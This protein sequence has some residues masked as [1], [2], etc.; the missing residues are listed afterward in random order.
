[1]AKLIGGAVQTS[2]VTTS[3]YDL[4]VAATFID[5]DRGDP[6]FVKNLSI[7]VD[8]GATGPVYVGGANLTGPA[9]AMVVLAAGASLAEILVTY[10][11]DLRDIFVQD[12][13]DSTIYI[14]GLQ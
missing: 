10:H 6:A 8:A 9:E 11:V 13:T 14:M 2:G 12:E 4:L 7:Q 5:P 1:M 3:L